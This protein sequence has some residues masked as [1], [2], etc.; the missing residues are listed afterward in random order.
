MAVLWHPGQ[1]DAAGRSLCPERNDSSGL[2]EC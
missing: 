2:S 1:G